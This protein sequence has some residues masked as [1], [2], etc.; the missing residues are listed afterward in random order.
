M[1]TK[2]FN[3]RWA[4]ILSSYCFVLDHVLGSKHSAD[5][6]SKRPDYAKNVESLPDSII[7]PSALRFLPSKSLPPDVQPASGTLSLN[8]LRSFLNASGESRQIHRAAELYPPSIL[9]S[10]RAHN[11]RLLSSTVKTFILLTFSQF[12]RMHYESYLYLFEELIIPTKNK[13]RRYF[14]LTH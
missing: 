9:I 10:P 11:I 5:N 1:T 14:R 13:N 4:E 8:V 12:K 7:P 3:R 6:R 2:I